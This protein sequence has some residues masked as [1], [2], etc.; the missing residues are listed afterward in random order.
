MRS[1]PSANDSPYL[2]ACVQDPGF[3]PWLSRVLTIVRNARP[4]TEFP[5]L[6]DIARKQGEVSEEWATA[7]RF[8]L[9][10]AIEGRDKVAAG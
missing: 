7:A 8:L 10:Q 3:M 1:E 5:V 6:L 2:P 4:G 9:L